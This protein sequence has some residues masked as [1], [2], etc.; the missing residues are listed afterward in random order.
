MLARAGAGAARGEGTRSVI[1][2]RPLRMRLAAAID[3]APARWRLL[4]VAE[5]EAKAAERAL[6][7]GGAL[8]LRRGLAVGA[9]RFTLG[10]Q[11]G[12]SRRRGEGEDDGSE[13]E[14]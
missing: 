3:G 14:G 5:T 10:D 6:V 12:R 1:G 7:D 13:A 2:E 9:G 4:G 11:F 8:G